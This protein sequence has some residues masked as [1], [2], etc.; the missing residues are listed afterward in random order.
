M[1]VFMYVCVFERNILLASLILLLAD[2]KRSNVEYADMKQRGY[3]EKSERN[4]EA[5]KK[6]KGGHAEKDAAKDVHSVDTEY[7]AVFQFCSLLVETI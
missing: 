2:L 5:E 6:E 7:P 4:M 1:C 3:S